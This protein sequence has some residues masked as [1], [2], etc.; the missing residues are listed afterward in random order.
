MS[1][2][3]GNFLP[4]LGVHI[5]V[6]NSALLSSF[7][8]CATHFLRFIHFFYISVV[9]FFLWLSNF[10]LNDY[11][12]LFIHSLDDEHLSCLKFGAIISRTRWLHRWILPNIWRTINTNPSQ[13]LLQI[14]KEGIYSNSF[15]KASIMQIP[16]LDTGITKEE[17]YRSGTMMDIDAKS[18]IN[19]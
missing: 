17:N 15:Y 5:N 6:N 9:H 3:Q 10:L 4:V 16:K 14:N 18:S 1:V 2:T 7:C 11:G 13:T 12:S 19:Y 8:C